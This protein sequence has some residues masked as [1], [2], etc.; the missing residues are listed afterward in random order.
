VLFTKLEVQRNWQFKFRP[1]TVQSTRCCDR[2]DPVFHSS[3]ARQSPFTDTHTDDR[4][5]ILAQGVRGTVTC[6]GVAK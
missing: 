3:A 2:N 5:R 6:A 4:A 1:R